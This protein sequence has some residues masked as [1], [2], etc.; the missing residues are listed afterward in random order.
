MPYRIHNNCVQVERNGRWQTMKCYESRREAVSYLGALEANVSQDHKSMYGGIPQEEAGYVTVSKTPGI[1]CG[2]CR[3]FRHAM[4]EHEGEAPHDVCLIVNGWPEPILDIGYCERWEEK[5]AP[6][7]HEPMPV[8]IVEPEME[9]DD[10]GEMAAVT[11]KQRPLVQLM[12]KVRDLLKTPETPVFSVFKANGRRWWLARHTGKFVDRDGEII[13]DHA[14]EEYVARVRQPGNERGTVPL[15][16]LQMWHAGKATR[17]G[18][19]DLVWKAGGFVMALGHFDDTAIAERA[20]RNYRR[21]RGKIKLSHGFHYSKA[22]KIDGVYHAYNTFEISTLPNGAE[23][24]PY[25]SFEELDMSGLSEGQRRWLEENGGK[26]LVTLAE[27]A[28]TRAEG[29]TTTLDKAG[30][31]SKNFDG[32]TLPDE[33]G[34]AMKA[35]LQGVALAL[36]NIGTALEPL[37]TLQADVKALKLLPD[38]VTAV[39]KALNAALEKQAAL[40]QDMAQLKDVQTPASRA[41]TTLLDT[42]DKAALA[43]IEEAAKTGSMPSIIDMAMGARPNMNGG[44]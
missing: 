24:F 40:E 28:T 23:A 14:H 41:N 32:V 27:S 39:Q 4:S 42:N 36:K 31:S 6:P 15:P 1:A 25:T 33:S 2:N 9:M 26:E 19:A 18:Q 3:F 7:E 11:E 13:A 35:A 30:I 43:R 8:V 34:E 21:K 22:H 16:E 5:P 20:Y 12:G 44:A 37:P 17:H 10:T 29:D 38:Q